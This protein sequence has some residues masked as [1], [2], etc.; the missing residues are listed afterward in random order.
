MIEG[1]SRDQEIYPLPF[2]SGIPS[3]THQNEEL[4]SLKF[5]AFEWFLFVVTSL[6]QR[7]ED[8]G[9]PIIYQRW[10]DFKF[11]GSNQNVIPI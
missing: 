9:H 8:Y 2:T 6:K 10:I 1:Y 7:V 3:Q 11:Q 5:Y 4:W